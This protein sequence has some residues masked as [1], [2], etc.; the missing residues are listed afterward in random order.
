MQRVRVGRVLSSSTT[1]FTVGCQALLPQVPSFGAFVKVVRYP[2]DI[3]D[4]TTIYGLIYNV[5]FQDDLLVRQLIGSPDIPEEVILDQRE[6]RQIPI[7]VSVLV[8]GF[9]DAT[10]VIRLYLP[11]QPPPA[12]HEIVLCDEEEIVELTSDA[13][14]CREYFRTVLGAGGDVP[15]DELLA[16]SLRHASICH[17][18]HC[19]RGE[20]DRPFLVEAGRELVAL[21]HDDLVRLNGILRRIKP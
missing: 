11:P 3:R 5:A 14:S 18:K 15:T 21:L 2:A 20:P 12:L 4:E 9:R 13:A 16:A 17:G 6:N 8:I 19:G 10:G 1:R 7:E